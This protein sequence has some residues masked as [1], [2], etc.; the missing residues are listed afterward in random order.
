M[1][2]VLNEWFNPQPQQQSQQR[3]PFAAFAGGGFGGRGAPEP[4]PEKPRIRVVAE[5]TSNSLLVRANTLVNNGT[6]A[7]GVEN[8]MPT[9]APTS[10]P[11]TNCRNSRANMSVR[12]GLLRS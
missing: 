5:Q 8:N 3:N 2:R 1:A 4:A 6:V 9:W 7:T 11:A 10:K 12:S